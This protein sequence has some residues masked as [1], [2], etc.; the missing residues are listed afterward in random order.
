MTQSVSPVDVFRD[1]LMSLGIEVARKDTS[2]S[3]KMRGALVNAAANHDEQ[4]TSMPWFRGVV[5]QVVLEELR[6]AA[7]QTAADAVG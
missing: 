7:G 6:R 2:E 1:D 4:I 5:R 3:R